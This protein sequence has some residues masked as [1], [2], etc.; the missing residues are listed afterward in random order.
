M[1]SKKYISFVTAVAITASMTACSDGGTAATE[2]TVTE[3]VAET[4]VPVESV[5]ETE[6]TT[7]ERVVPPMDTTPITLS[8]YIDNPEYAAAF[9]TP[10]AQAITE[11]TGVTLEFIV[12]EDE[13]GLDTLLE[14]GELPDLIYA[15]ERTDELVENGTLIPLDEYVENAGE[16]YADMYA[17]NLDSL[18]AEDGKLYTFGTGGSAPA[19]FTAEGTFQIQYAVLAELGYPEINTLEQLGDCLKQYLE[20]HPEKKGLLLCGAPQQQ[21]LDTVSLRINYLLGCPDDSEFLVNEE[22]GE[23]A[24]KWT[25]ERTYEIVKWLN[26]MYN[27]GVLDEKSFSMKHDAYVDRISQGNTLAIA[28]KYEDYTP[29][30]EI[31][32]AAGKYDR[33][34]CPIEVTLYEDAKVPFLADYGDFAVSNGIGITSACKEPERA[35]RFLDWWC[36][37]EAQ[38]IVNFA[39]DD[40]N[41]EYDPASETYYEDTG[42]ALYAE[43]FPMR[44]LT[45]KNSDGDY[46]SATVSKHISAYSEPQK[47]AAE[48]YGITLFAEL[49]T[50]TSELPAYERT[51]ISDME[52]HAL[53]EEGILLESLGTYVKTEVQNAIKLPTEEFDAKWKEITEWCHSNGADDLEKIMTGYVKKDMGIS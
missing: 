47:A 12:P 15:G 46:Y 42:A 31:L 43:P 50:Q 41:S 24:Y 37:D 40:I 49:F 28:D 7:T 20:L 18:R 30:E 14:S 29:A 27:D 13:N 34:Y 8:L 44:C 53:S 23:V 3:T 39:T 1:N 52:I 10:V 45:E 11:R 26:Q 5:T 9:D 35:F 21:W 4:T 25:D 19:Q 6:A 33:M 22:T 36:S 16:F 38:E 17:E 32:A 51:L 2:T 48:A